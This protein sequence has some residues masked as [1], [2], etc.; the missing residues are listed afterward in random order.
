M[1]QWLRGIAR[2]W[3]HPLVQIIHRIDASI[4][5]W[6]VLII[7]KKHANAFKCQEQ[8]TLGPVEESGHHGRAIIRGDMEPCN[9]GKMD[10]CQEG[11]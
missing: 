2:K 7:G 9:S 10:E 6:F 1:N 5:D 11:K 4:G 8:L 3:V